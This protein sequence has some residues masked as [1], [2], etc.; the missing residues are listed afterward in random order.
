MRLVR[1]EMYGFKSFSNKTEFSFS[2]GITGFVGPNGGGKSNVV[3]A[4]R[5]VL[6]EQN[7]RAIR[8]NKMEDLIFAGSENSQHKN[9]A[10][11]SIVLDN[12]D[13]EIPLD[14]REVT[15]TRRY[16]RSG[17]SEYFLNR[18]PCRLKDIGEVLAATSLGRGTYAIIGQGQVEEVI[19]SRPEDR[20]QMF[21]EAAGIAL[22]KLRKRDA[23]KKLADTRIHL[24][25]VDDIVH[26]LQNQENEVSESAA[27]ASEYLEHKE[28]ADI[29]EKSLWAGKYSE[30]LKRLERLEVRKTELKVSKKDRQEQ[31][32]LKEQMLAE[33]AGK[34]QECSEVITALEQGKAQ[35]TGNKTELEYQ[36]QLSG[37]RQQ[38]FHSL[39]LSANQQLARLKSQVEESDGGIA[40]AQK[41]IHTLSDQINTYMIAMKRRNAAAGL[42][43]RL[44]AAVEFCRGQADNLII[45]AA[46]DSTESASTR[47]KAKQAEAELLGQQATVVQ[48]LEGWEVES[49]QALEEIQK[50]DKVI[51]QAEE[52]RHQAAPLQQQLL[53]RLTELQT[54]RSQSVDRINKLENSQNALEQKLDMFKAM[55]QDYQGFNPGTR[56]ALKASRDKQLNGVLGAVA[57]LLHVADPQHSLAVETALGGAMQYVVCT[58]E[59][60]CRTAIELLKKTNG[61]RATFIP[62]AAAEQRSQG[63]RRQDFKQPIVGWAD[64]LVNCPGDLKSVAAMFLGNVLVTENLIIATKLAIE[65][66]YRYKIVTLEGEVISRG[67]FT[68]GSSGKTRQGLLQR[69]AGVA[70]LTAQHSNQKQILDQLRRELTELNSRC[71]D[72]D[73]QISA[74]QLTQD[75]LDKEI[76]RFQTQADQAKSRAAQADDR[77]SSCG[78]RLAV[79]AQKIKQAQM[80]LEGL[81]SQISQDK[82]GLEKIQADK[83]ML[84]ELEAS[85]KE[86]VSIWASHQNS[87]QLTV[88]SLQNQRENRQRQLKHLQEQKTELLERC[89][90]IEEEVNGYQRQDS[91]LR[92]KLEQTKAAL[93]EIF[94]GLDSVAASLESQLDAQKLLREEID[95]ISRQASALKDELVQINNSLHESEVKKARWQSEDEALARE[96]GSR[97]GISPQ[98]GLANLDGRYTVNELSASL[99]KLQGR[100]H[101]MGDINLASIQQHKKLQ[102]RL[103]FLTGQKYDLVKAEQ[104][105]LGLV[106]ELDKNI[107]QLFLETFTSVQEHFTEI[108]KVLFDGGSAYLS[109][110]DED[111]LLETGIE[112]FARP[113]GKKT[114]SLSLLS[115]GEKSMTAIALLFALQSVRPSPFCILDEIEAALDDVNILRFAKYL[116][117]LAGEMQFILI[118]H[119]RETME[120]SDSLY[121]I[122]LGPDGSSKPISVVLKKDERRVSGI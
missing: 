96:L 119:R 12:K 86:M 72:L 50:L 104:D 88:Y 16:Y 67:L 15:V 90:S 114:Q 87:I 117:Q 101:E 21:E 89:S 58:D 93:A 24:T 39:V 38:D 107:R 46:M 29:V 44:L 18:V 1:L 109:L 53:S 110:S 20:R 66:N 59:N 8:A 45:Q 6:G 27:K 116:R 81:G 121:G 14:Y 75:A 60:S 95:N 106:G 111:D 98:Q 69:R 2:P 49:R 57:E 92:D 7:P 30:L 108:F 73:A 11:V 56:A 22:F 33:S 17:E 42:M 83:T 102:E 94:Q 36:L 91:L 43:R 3:D 74:N 65:I 13:N 35:L 118:T 103:E 41:E 31:L 40:G 54:S 84:Q 47:D 76:F 100:I 113:P 51:S 19:S 105:I 82:A 61:G 26:E 120:N 25:R 77:I 9:Y 99:R 78:N 63:S 80:A 52:N 48:E 23:M 64:Q 79:L 5:W 122:T 112:I 62:V 115:G 68:G 37:Q 55:E 32:D 34:I 28:Q 10:E 85:L 97:F 70:E 4:I 71:K